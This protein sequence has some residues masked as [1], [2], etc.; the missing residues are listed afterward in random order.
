MSDTTS[1]PI[2]CRWIRFWS[3]TRLVRRRGRRQLD[4]EG[5]EGDEV[6]LG[7]GVGRGVGEEG[8]V[9]LEGGDSSGF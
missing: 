2:R 7:D 6:D 4:R 5:D 1:F 3:T 8:G 9:L